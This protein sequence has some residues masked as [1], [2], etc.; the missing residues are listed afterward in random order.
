MSNADSGKKSSPAPPAYITGLGALSAVES[1]F[2]RTI[3]PKSRKKLGEKSLLKSKLCARKQ[4]EK[5]NAKNP[6]NLLKEII[7]VTT[8]NKSF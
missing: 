2:T 8:K 1:V 7:M 3:G 4:N 6:K 5:K